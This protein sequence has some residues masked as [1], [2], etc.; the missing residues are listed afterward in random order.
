VVLW[1]GR[2]GVNLWIH[3][4]SGFDAS[5]VIERAAALGVLVAPGE[6]FYLSPGHSDV[7]RFNVGS[8]E[9]ERVSVCAELLVKAIQQS[10]G[11]RSTAIHV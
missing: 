2:D 7:V 11:A 1:P 3:L 9:T 10:G 4:P 5:E 6:V 8:V